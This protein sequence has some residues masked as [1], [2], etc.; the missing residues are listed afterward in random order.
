[1][2]WRLWRKMYLTGFI[3]LSDHTS[4]TI[5]EHK[6]SAW[7]A[8]ITCLGPMFV[9][10]LDFI[11]PA[12]LMEAFIC[13]YIHHLPQMCFVRSHQGVNFQYLKWFQFSEIKINNS[14]NACTYMYE[15]VRV[16]YVNKQT[17]ICRDALNCDPHIHKENK[18]IFRQVW[19][20]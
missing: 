18:W 17:E 19:M 2:D 11:T 5:N 14:Y 6:W 20:K 13:N 15:C 10:F 7:L 16:L 3:W 12:V 4:A 8:F 1:M 9:P